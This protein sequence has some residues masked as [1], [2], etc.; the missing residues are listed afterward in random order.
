[1]VQTLN[2]EQLEIRHHVLVW[3]DLLDLLQT[4]DLN[5]LVIQNALTIWLAYDRNAEIH[6][7][8]RVDKTRNVEL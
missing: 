4:V 2:V 3:K 6:V 7:Q 1:M 8:E 5:V